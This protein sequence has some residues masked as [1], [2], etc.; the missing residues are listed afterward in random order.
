MSNMNGKR[1]GLWWKLLLWLLP[2]AFLLIFFYQPLTA[3]LRLA[4]SMRAEGGGQSFLPGLAAKTFAFTLWQAVLS[5]LLTLVIGLP[6]AYL[7]SHYEFAGRKF[8]RLIALLPFILPT[9]VVAVS[10]NSLLGP[11]GWLNVGLMALFGLSE[12]PVRLLNSLPA[13]LLAHVFYNSS[14]IIRIVGGAWSRLDQKLTQAAQMLGANPWQ[15]FWEVTFPLLLPAAAGASLLVF[16]FD[17]TSFGVVLMLG[18]PAFATLEVEIYT[19]ALY[20]FNLPLAGLLSLIQ[21]A[22]TLLVAWAHNRVSLP[23]YGKAALSA[24]KANLRPPRTKKEKVFT[25]VTAAVLIALLLLPLLSLV[26]RSLVSLEAERGERG[27]AQTGFTLR[28]YRELFRDTT[29]S[30]FYVPPAVAVRN[31]VLYAAAAMLIANM[32]GLI[33]SYALHFSGRLARW[34]EPVLILPLGASAVTLGLGF[35]I[36]FRRAP[37]D[38]VSFSIL[39]PFA[40]ALV[41]L[42]LVVRTL[43]PALRGIPDS[44]RQAASTLGAGWA[45]VFREVDLPLLLRPLL[46]C[47]VFAFTISLGEFGAS[48]FLSTGRNPTIP[49]A[50]YRYISQPGALNYGQ[51]LAMSTILLVVCALGSLAIEKARLPGEELF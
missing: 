12:P 42:P 2:A 47:M 18:G 31:S 10:F 16:L 48:S 30:I 38:G 46:V 20:L 1:G 4:F 11:R 24:E 6:A 33:T 3:I 5:T 35:V 14:I 29:G 45:R 22:F 8:L 25:F 26:T 19:Q 23:R 50:I 27:E 34:L 37:W 21:L 7:F 13:I 9:V 39:I 44:L 51:A 36:V 28:Y 49:V 41:A 17:F 40:H 15:V 43:L 32:L